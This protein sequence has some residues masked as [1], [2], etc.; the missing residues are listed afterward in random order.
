MNPLQN[1]H[2]TSDI[3][4]HYKIPSDIKVIEYPTWFNYLPLVHTHMASSIHKTVYFPKDQFVDLTSSKPSVLVLSVLVHELVHV[5]RSLELGFTVFG[6][7]YLFSKKFCLQEELSAIEEQ[8]KFLFAHNEVYNI[9]RKARHF[10]GSEYR[11]VLS[12]EEG[13]GVLEKL[14]EK[15]KS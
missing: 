9:E 7:S 5:R 3:F 1:L 6:L 8:M 15:V 10:A 11:N 2:T 12:L 13:R 14:W 4:E